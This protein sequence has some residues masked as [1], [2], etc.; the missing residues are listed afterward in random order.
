MLLHPTPLPRRG[1]REFLRV[2]RSDEQKA[3][4]RVLALRP[5]VT[6]A[7]VP[8][9]CLESTRAAMWRSPGNASIRIS[10][11]LPSSSVEK[12]LVPVILLSGR[13]IEFTIPDP[14]ISSVVPRMGIVVVARC[15]ARIAASPVATM[16][17]TLALTSSAANSGIGSTCDPYSCQS[18]VRFSPSTKPARRSSSKTPSQYGAPRG[19]TDKPPIR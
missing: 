17:S 10:C 19:P 16:T 15:T 13:A 2:S 6:E 18:M 11:R 14:T 4:C 5:A 7:E 9:L 12:R 8:R 3:R 1:H